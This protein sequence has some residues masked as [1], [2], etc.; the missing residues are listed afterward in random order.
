MKK[1]NTNEKWGSDGFG[2]N[3]L[4]DGFH[5]RLLTLTDMKRKDAADAHRILSLAESAPDL[6]SACESAYELLYNQMDDAEQ[7]DH[8][9]SGHDAETC[10]LCQL[11]E[12]IEKGKGE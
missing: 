3:D 2:I 12:A 6:L 8:M 7:L 4:N 5:S 10:V 1:E 9:T 11:Q